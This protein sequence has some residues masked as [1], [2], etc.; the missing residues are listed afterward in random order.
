MMVYFYLLLFSILNWSPLAASDYNRLL[1]EPTSVE[2]VQGTRGAQ[3]WSV[4]KVH[5]GDNNLG[6]CFTSTRVTQQLSAEGGL[7][8]RSIDQEKL[9]PE[10]SIV[11]Y[12][13]FKFCKET[14]RFS[15]GFWEK[16]EH[17]K[18]AI[19]KAC[20]QELKTVVKA[21]EAEYQAITEKLQK[22]CNAAIDRG[23]KEGKNDAYFATCRECVAEEKLKHKE[24]IRGIIKTHDKVFSTIEKHFEGFEEILTSIF[25]FISL[26]PGAIKLVA[27]PQKHKKQATKPSD[28]LIT[29]AADLHNSQLIKQLHGKS[30]DL[31][32]FFEYKYETTYLMKF[33]MECRDRFSKKLSSPLGSIDLSATYTALVPSEFKL[34]ANFYGDLMT[35]IELFQKEMKEKG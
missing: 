4:Y 19:L 9:I 35:E 16:V 6:N 17:T 31:N 26:D 24:R 27:E 32:S 7:C 21:C 18:T 28:R 3:E 20:Q 2:Q 25:Y 33:L 8:K 15:G 34:I 14:M 22:A 30:I 29:L 11:N 12:K 13:R 5:E 1:E 23:L 10:S